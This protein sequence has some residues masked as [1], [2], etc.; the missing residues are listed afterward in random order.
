M[1]IRIDK[2]TVL[3]TGVLGSQIAYQTAYSGFEITAYDIS[4][5]IIKAARKR[6][7][8]LAA[9][10]ERE[11]E[12]SAGGRAQAALARIKYSSSLADAVRDADL[13][14]ESAPER[15]DVKRELLG[16]LAPLAPERT[17]FAT[18]TST[19][20]PSALAD[21]T[22]RPDR[23]LALHFTNEIWIRNV[24]EIMGHPGTS[25]AVYD[26]TVEFARR[27]GMEPIEIHKEQ[28]G[29]V[30]NSL[31]VP[32]LQSALSLVVNGVADPETIDKT[33][34]I[35]TRAPEGPL[36]L[37]DIAGLNTIYNIAAA[38]DEQGKANARYI[39]EHYIDKG[40]LGRASGEGFY[41]YEPV[42]ARSSRSPVTASD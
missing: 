31:L 37:V 2:V 7:E 28:P 3:G 14:I 32:F 19:L 11:V 24:A 22:G 17:I 13:V 39:K 23:F 16:K 15:L 9:R 26:A 12:G 1:T 25:P 8:E 5:E 10:Y 41:K 30:I 4:D 35:T 6:F 27:I 36:Q 40:K 21:A 34:R 18:N 20:L 42:P 29:Y 38:R 33:W